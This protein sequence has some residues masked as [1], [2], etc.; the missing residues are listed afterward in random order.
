MREVVAPVLLGVALFGAFFA[1]KL[2]ADQVPVLS[3]SV[4]SVL[5]RADAGPLALVLGIALVNGVGEEIFFRGAV[6]SAFG[7]NHAALWATAVYC[8]VTVATLNLALVAAALVMGSVFS[9][10]RRATG[11]VLAPV[12]THLSWSTLMVCLLPR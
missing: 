1:A 11:G 5:A 8:A 12:I 7:A 2:I 3:G 9:A 10:E 6:Q 4:A